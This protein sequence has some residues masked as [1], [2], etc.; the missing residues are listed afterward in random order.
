MLAKAGAPLVLMP[1]R[2]TKKPACR[3]VFLRVMGAELSR[4]EWMYFECSLRDFC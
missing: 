3:L 2:T 4:Q 1:E